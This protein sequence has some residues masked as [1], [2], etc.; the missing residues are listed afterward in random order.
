[1]AA[2]DLLFSWLRDAH[3]MEKALADFGDRAVK[4]FDDQPEYQE[5]IRSGLERSREHREAVE[6]ILKDSDAGTSTGKDIMAKVTSFV[7]GMGSSM[8]S[9]DRTKDFLVMHGALH[10][11][12]ASYMSLA[13]AANSCGE[14]A[15]ATTC[16]RIAREKEEMAGIVMDRIPAV[17]AMALARENDGDN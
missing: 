17:T 1:M 16:E 14:E 7:S 2:K 11:A 3:S 12:H 8:F 5:L 4:D 6:A 10:F 15:I 13:H 9:D